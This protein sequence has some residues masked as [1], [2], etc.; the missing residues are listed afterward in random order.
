VGCRLK[1][2]SCAGVLFLGVGEV[3]CNVNWPIAGDSALFWTA[4]GRPL[5]VIPG[6]CAGQ[7]QANVGVR[8]CSSSWMLVE[9]MQLISFSVCHNGGFAG[10]H[11]K[12]C[13]AGGG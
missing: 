1:S 2:E 12:S 8:R 5:E 9:P 4:L 7:Q 3:S 10:V 6:S 11:G 13:D